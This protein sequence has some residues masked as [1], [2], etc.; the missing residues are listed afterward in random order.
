MKQFSTI[1]LC[2]VLFFAACSKSEDSVIPNPKLDFDFEVDL[3]TRTV[4]FENKSEGVD[5]YQWNFGDKQLSAEKSPVHTYSSAGTFT[6][7]LT[8]K[9]VKTGAQ[10]SL[11]K[12]VVVG[13]SQGNLPNAQLAEPTNVDFAGCDIAWTNVNSGT[14]EISRFVQVSSTYNF[15]N[16][17]MEGKLESNA[18]LSVNDLTP[19]TD[20]W[21]RIKTSFLEKGKAESTITYSNIK[22]FTTSNLPDPSVSF[23]NAVEGASYN[24]FKVIKT[25]ITSPHLVAKAVSYNLNVYRMVEKGVT[26]PAI[27][28]ANLSDCY[29]KEP[30]SL[31]VAEYKATYQ[32]VTKDAET[33]SN[34]VTSSFIAN[35]GNGK[36][37]S[38]SYTKMYQSNGKTLLELGESETGKKVVFQI[39]NFKGTKGATFDLKYNA[40]SSAD[41]RNSINVADDTY[42]YL[43][44]GTSAYKYYLTAPNQRLELYFVTDTYYFFRTKASNGANTL[45]FTQDKDD[46]I[47]N[48]SETIYE[49]YFVV[50]R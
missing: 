37:W 8:A 13:S 35:M 3:G 47:S 21:I 6:V 25:N 10:I 19:K 42:A 9:S 48:Q 7:I 49:T 44:N 27:P 32:N 12:E 16:I 38:G 24:V 15:S 5:T 2:F 4:R 50:K 40:L 29:I 31:F 20:Y 30:S 46:V 23:V 34:F 45:A 18:A 39:A 11:Q 26:V 41:G 28:V 17:V 22:T 1:T 33:Q 14:G 36:G 43:L